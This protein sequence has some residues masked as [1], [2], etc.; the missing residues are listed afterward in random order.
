MHVEVSHSWDCSERSNEI[1]KKKNSFQRTAQYAQLH[2]RILF[3]CSCVCIGCNK[4]HQMHFGRF[5]FLLLLIIFFASECND[6]RYLWH[7]INITFFTVSLRQAQH[8]VYAMFYKFY[9]C[10]ERR[11]FCSHRKLPIIQYIFNELFALYSRSWDTQLKIKKK[12]IK[13]RLTSVWTQTFWITLANDK[14]TQWAIT[15]AL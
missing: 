7:V 9:T 15:L 3:M 8:N 11:L 2:I 4:N 6:Q 13:R 1:K 12:Q 14:C 10:V 5:V